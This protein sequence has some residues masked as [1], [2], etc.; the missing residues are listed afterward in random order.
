MFFKF[1]CQEDA[2][3]SNITTLIDWISAYLQQQQQQQQQRQQQQRQ[4]QQQMRL[5]PGYWPVLRLQKNLLHA[6]RLP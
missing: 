1:R 5:S 6:P 3:R 4:Q 2:A